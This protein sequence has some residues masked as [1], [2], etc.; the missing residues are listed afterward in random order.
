[1]FPNALRDP[2]ALFPLFGVYDGVILTRA[3]GTLNSELLNVAPSA[4]AC[5]TSH[6]TL[7]DGVVSN[8]KGM[9]P[10]PNLGET[11]NW[12]I[13]SSNPMLLG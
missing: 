7:Y 5:R 4:Y 11:I 6:Q 10:L 13:P 2:V 3:S 8:A 12:S 9:L 1:M